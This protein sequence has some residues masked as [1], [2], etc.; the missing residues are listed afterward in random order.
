M[1][2]RSAVSSKKD[3]SSAD[4]A[5][6]QLGMCSPAVEMARTS[7]PGSSPGGQKA[8]GYVGWE[9]L[10]GGPFADASAQAIDVV[11]GECLAFGDGQFPGIGHGAGLEVCI[12][13]REGIGFDPP[14]G[15]VLGVEDG[16]GGNVGL[17][18]PELRHEETPLR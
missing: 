1:T 10:V 15:H 11:E 7:G 17:E 12:Y 3:W 4:K 2:C 5:R 14:G 13:R 16:V 9:C 18:F 6:R 8:Q